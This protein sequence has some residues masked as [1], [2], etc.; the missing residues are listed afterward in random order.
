MQRIV[1]FLVGVIVFCFALAQLC[2][3]EVQ[4]STRLLVG[5]I[6]VR[7]V[8]RLIIGRIDWTT[9]LDELAINLIAALI[10]V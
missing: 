9:F 6:V 1:R 10:L 7:C 8:A 5:I 4:R 2:N 3:A